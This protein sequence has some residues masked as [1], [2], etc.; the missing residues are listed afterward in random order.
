MKILILND[1]YKY[2][3]A[4][5]AALKQLELLSSCNEKV[6]MITL[7]PAY[8]D[9]L[10]EKNIYNIKTCSDS[11]INILNK[12][13]FSP[14]IYL[15]LRRK[16]EEFSPDVIFLHGIL[17]SPISQYMAV[18]G[19]KCIQTVH[20]YFYICPKFNCIL[21][22]G[23]VCK[24][25]KYRSCC[26]EGCLYDGSKAKLM[27][28]RYISAVSRILRKHTVSCFIAPSKR[29]GAYLDAYGYKNVVIDN[30]YAVGNA[31]IGKARDRRS[32]FLYAGRI[33]AD[34]GIFEFLDAFAKWNSEGK[35]SITIAGAFS[36]EDD[37]KRFEKLEDRYH[38]ISY[39][40][41]KSHEE[42]LDMMRHAGFVVVPSLGIEN[43]PTA[44]L[45]AFSA[46]A[47]VIG[48]A[49]GGVRE[50]ISEGRGI[51]FKILSCDDIIRKLSYAV[52]LSEEEKERIRQ[53]GI[54]YLKDN[55]SEE[56]YLGEIMEL[57]EKTVSL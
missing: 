3:G 41:E 8:R 1:L 57:A 44:V 33:S 15:R 49:R 55:N 51:G 35:H 10:I 46:G 13:L 25:T 36:S 16:I 29:L 26:K 12:V 7:D 53:R 19:Y 4:E 48:S 37:R 2:G 21:P 20:D 17:R 45:D 31:A 22:E 43:Y 39:E 27:I 11:R 34:K 30:P 24:G 54:R 18:R 38:W 5:L 42:I 9:G 14:S 23:S 28:F 56:K 50:L 47:V 32:E 40:G 52:K 6:M